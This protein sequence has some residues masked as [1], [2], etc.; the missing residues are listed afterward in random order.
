LEQENNTIINENI[1]QTREEKELNF[2][3]LNQVT[4]AGVLQHDPPIRWTKKGV[5]VT[6][7]LLRVIPDK[8]SN[9]FEET[10]R[11]ECVISVV[12]WAKQALQCKKYLKK[13]SA[14]IIAGEIQSMPNAKPDEGFYPVQINAQWIQYLDKSLGE[15]EDIDDEQFTRQGSG[16]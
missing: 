10:K 8:S 7:F 14:V 9:L 4:I 16:E 3:D 6:N 5:P 15:I 1:E 12:V 2:P 11:E 13:D